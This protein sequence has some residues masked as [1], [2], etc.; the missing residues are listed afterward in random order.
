MKNKQ[1]LKLEAIGIDFDDTIIKEP[2]DWKTPYNQLLLLPNAR[3]IINYLYEKYQIIIV[4]S[5]INPEINQDYLDHIE[6]IEW[7]LR[8]RGVKFDELA[9]FKPIVQYN[10]DNRNVEFDGNWLKLR[11]KLELKE[12]DA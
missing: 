11:K 8:D 1:R 9:K 2:K 5:R 4:S 12:N 6:W 3:E 7:Y 10:I